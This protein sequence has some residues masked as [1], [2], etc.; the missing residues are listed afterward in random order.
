ML[1]DV[2]IYVVGDYDENEVLLS[3]VLNS[4]N[5]CINYFTKDKT[6]KTTLLDNYENVMLCIDEMI[7]EGIIITLESKTII[8]RAT[9]QDTDSI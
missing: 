3:V 8:A 9:M 6:S 1:S 7:D 5:D 4:L 2:I